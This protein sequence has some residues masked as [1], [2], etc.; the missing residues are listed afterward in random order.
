MRLSAG[1]QLYTNAFTRRNGL[2]TKYLTK[3]RHPPLES[4]SRSHL[5]G[6]APCS[7][8]YTNASRAISTCHPVTVA[9]GS[10]PRDPAPPLSPASAFPW[11]SRLSLSLE[12]FFLGP[13]AIL[14]TS[15][16]GARTGIYGCAGPSSNV[17]ISHYIFS[18]VQILR[19]TKP[20]QIA[21]HQTSPA[22]DPVIRTYA[23][24]SRS[25]PQALL[26]HLLQ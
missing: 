9:R 17:A 3:Y 18:F 16:T 24:Q 8:K 14:F 22:S 10:A 4:R 15:T 11:T 5:Y 23:P 26:F 19:E 25:L 6:P 2:R 13:G 7:A 20:S 1:T 12:S 21:W